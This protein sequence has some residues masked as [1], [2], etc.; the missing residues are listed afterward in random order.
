MLE[1]LQITLSEVE[2]AQRAKLD[3]L[4]ELNAARLHE[5]AEIERQLAVSLLQQRQTRQELFSSSSSADVFAEEST[6]SL[7]ALISQLPSNERP[8]LLAMLLSLQSRAARIKEQ[9]AMNW[10]TT[11]RLNEYVSDMLE[12][13]AHAGRP[14]M[15]EV[16]HGLMLDS[17]A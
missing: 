9:V 7:R 14:A 1:N 4:K 10:L 2:A 15:E 13:V 11:W 12:I 16:H 8:S 3:A 6:T 17:Q 5:S